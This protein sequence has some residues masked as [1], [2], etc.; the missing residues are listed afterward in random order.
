M[1][2]LLAG[3]ANYAETAA[4]DPALSWAT[5]PY[6]RVPSGGGQEE[7]SGGPGCVLLFPGQGSHYVGMGR[8][9]MTCPPAREVYEMASQV[10][11][12]DVAR[13][14][15]DGPA[16]ELAGRSQ[17]CITVTSLAALERLREER[18]RAVEEARAVAG[19]SLGE[20]AA[21][22]FAGALPREQALR[23]VAVREAA[24]T[25]ATRL[26]PGG[27]L[28][29]WPAPDADMSGALRAARAV[30]GP[31]GQPA[32]CAVANYLH[33]GC[34]VIAGDEAALRELERVARSHGLR[35][36]ARL[37]VP[38]AFHSTCMQPALAPLREALRSCSVSDPRL[39]VISNVDARPYRHAAHIR[40]Q[41]PLQVTILASL[42]LEMLA[43][44]DRF[45]FF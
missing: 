9:L 26:R 27:M 18:P 30:A 40:R 36:T 22:V 10:L 23:L 5:L 13:L 20:L 34:K 35:R 44:R 31:D 29:V 37:P 45:W 39:P 8:A 3:A 41:L 17:V 15:T 38:G 42:Y 11:G 32:V 2:R 24:A 43:R 16:D 14:C 4:R 1:R 19:F 25:A 7:P 21:L 28:V 33:P 6:T 12:W